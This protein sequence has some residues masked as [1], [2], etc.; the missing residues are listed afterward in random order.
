MLKKISLRKILVTTSLLFIILVIYLIPRENKYVLSTN[1]NLKYVGCLDN[2]Q[3]VYLINSNNYLGKTSILIS[4]DNKNIELKIKELLEVLIIDGKY[5]NNIP[6]GFRSFIPVNTKILD[7][8]Y[9]DGLVIVNFS[10][11]LLDIS[12]LYED[13]VIE[14]IVYT[15]TTINEVKKVQIKVDGNLLTK[16]PKS[17]IILPEYLT[18]SYGINKTYNLITTKD[19]QEVIVYYL[20]EYNDQ[21]YYVPVTKYVNNN[22]DK[23][24]IIIDELTSAPIYESNLMS[25]LNS[26]I[27]LLN[28]NLDNNIMTLDF[29]EYI[30]SD[31]NSKNI[32][33]EVVY[34]IAYSIYDNYDV[35]EVVF[36]YNNEKVIDCIS[37][38]CEVKNKN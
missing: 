22:N 14:A 16:L 9:K 31:M 23:I 32:L 18:K 25:F 7:V 27:K 3:E 37:K 15:L 30:F 28:Y 24:K 29:N 38:V 19:I 2:C 6:N 35:N 4:N 26:N 33:E 21:Y 11:E 12:E 5:E 10:K 13:K 20:N 1:Q 34:G 8:V 36:R 17:N